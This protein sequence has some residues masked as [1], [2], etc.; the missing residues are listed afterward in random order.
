MTPEEAAQCR[1]AELRG[2]RI[3][4]VMVACLVAAFVSLFRSG[5]ELDKGYGSI[6][7]RGWSEFFGRLVF[8]LPICLGVVWFLRSSE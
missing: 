8:N 2:T 7:V 5:R 4:A 3:V 6:I 1:K